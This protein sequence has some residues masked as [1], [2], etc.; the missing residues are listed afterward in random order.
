MGRLARISSNESAWGQRGCLGTC[1]QPKGTRL[2]YGA[3]VVGTPF[4]QSQFEVYYPANIPQSHIENELSA[5]VANRA[6][7]HQQRLML[8]MIALPF[9]A[10]FGVVPGPN[11]PLIWN[12]YRLYSNWRALQG[13]K[14]LQRAKLEDRLEFIGDTNTEEILANWQEGYLPSAAVKSLGAEWG[15]EL[16]LGVNHACQ[17]HQ[18]SNNAETSGQL[19]K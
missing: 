13:G 2:P 3:M 19:H 4:L 16:C 14:T 15:D 8:C 7:H 5:I 18:K 17:E 10:L 1:I 6:P 11:V 12:L 9:S